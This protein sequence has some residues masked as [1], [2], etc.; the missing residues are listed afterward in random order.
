MYFCRVLDQKSDQIVNT[1]LIN[2]DKPIPG[3]APAGGGAIPPGIKEELSAFKNAQSL[4]QH[5]LEDLRYITVEDVIYPILWLCDYHIIS[6]C[7][8]DC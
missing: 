7:Y 4:V 2:N 8:R 5:K 6:S 3:G 1:L